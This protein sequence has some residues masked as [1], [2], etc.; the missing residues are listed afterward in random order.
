MFESKNPY[1]TEVVK[2][3]S[4]REIIIKLYA[5]CFN[6]NIMVFSRS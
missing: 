3:N 1:K 6:H 2:I 4:G 5:I